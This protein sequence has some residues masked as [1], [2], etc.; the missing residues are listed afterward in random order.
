MPKDVDTEGGKV[1]GSDPNPEIVAYSAWGSRVPL[2]PAF[3]RRDWM[4]ATAG[5][6]AY[7]CLPMTLANQ[8]GWFVLA[9]MGRGRSGTGATR[10]RT[11][12]SRSKGLRSRSTRCRR[13]AAAS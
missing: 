7:H 10:R 2:V 12:W 8:S 6:F 4:D 1:L 11:W 9:L 5:G 3:Y 13:S